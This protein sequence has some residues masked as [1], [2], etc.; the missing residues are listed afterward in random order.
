M[1]EED[2]NRKENVSRIELEKM[3]IERDHTF[4]TL[5]TE[6]KKIASIVDIIN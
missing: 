6:K 1:L 4:L 3:K 2:V 5:A